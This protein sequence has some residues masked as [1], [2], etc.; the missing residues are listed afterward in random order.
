MG[1]SIN[2]SG[3]LRR[4]RHQGCTHMKERPWEDTEGGHLKAK[5]RGLGTNEPANPFMVNF[6]PPEL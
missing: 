6:Q 4:E 3:V 2:T 5:D 1:S